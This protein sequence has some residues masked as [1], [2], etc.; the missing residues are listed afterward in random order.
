MF[1]E[2][3]RRE[4]IQLGR[5]RAQSKNP[6]NYSIFSSAGGLQNPKIFS[7]KFH[8]ADGFS[9]IFKAYFITQTGL[10]SCL[11]IYFIA[12]ETLKIGKLIFEL[13]FMSPPAPLPVDDLVRI[14][15]DNLHRELRTG[16]VDRI[17]ESLL[18]KTYIVC[19]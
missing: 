12:A 9:N 3:W 15:V 19:S 11:K 2:R 13:C 16:A 7:D 6:W 1:C 8:G 10:H 17:Y 18:G 5:F 14:S 4:Q